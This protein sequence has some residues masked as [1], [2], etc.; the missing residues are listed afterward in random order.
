MTFKRL[1][2]CLLVLL[3]VLSFAPVLAD[4]YGKAVI[5][6]PSGKLHLRKEA[7]SDSDSLGLFFTGTNL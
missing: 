2:I 6:A 4:D 1:S 7:S 3:M 5:D